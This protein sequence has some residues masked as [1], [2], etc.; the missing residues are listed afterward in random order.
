VL[1]FTD[2]D[3][4]REALSS[5]R[6][7]EALGIGRVGRIDCADDWTG[8]AA[9]TTKRRASIK[10]DRRRDPGARGEGFPQTG[11]RNIAGNYGRKREPLRWPFPAWAGTATSGTQKRVRLQQ[12]TT[13]M[14]PTGGDG[15]N[16]R[17]RQRERERGV[18]REVEGREGRD[19][20]RKWERMQEVKRQGG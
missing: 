10:R 1:A 2:D 16:E 20:R 5:E 12:R 15:R 6:G 14:N 8:D 18:C 7:D 4:E 11:R 17:C 19:E 3:D 9:A 13:R